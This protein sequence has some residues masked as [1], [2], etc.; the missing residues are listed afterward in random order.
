[1]AGQ[2]SDSDGRC[3]GSLS[4]ASGVS[5][6]DD[7]AA[8]LSGRRTLVAVVE[9][10][11]GS[12]VLWTTRGPADSQSA[13]SGLAKPVRQVRPARGELYEARGVVTFPGGETV[14]SAWRGSDSPP[15]RF[16]D[17]VNTGPPCDGHR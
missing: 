4:A 15:D 12:R 5:S 3:A 14:N 6:A 2:V 1:M 16:T 13:R 11:D 7:M 9:V 10:A 8:S 17:Q